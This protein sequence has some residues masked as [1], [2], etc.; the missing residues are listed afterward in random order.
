MFAGYTYMYV[1]TYVYAFSSR[2]SVQ[3]PRTD[4]PHEQYIPF[5]WRSHEG[6]WTSFSI[7]AAASSAL[8]SAKSTKMTKNHAASVFKV[9]DVSRSRK[10]GF[11]APRCREESRKNH[12]SKKHSWEIACGKTLARATIR[13][14]KRKDDAL[15]S[16]VI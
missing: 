12:S 5:S 14:I 1:Y 9:I 10:L 13:A 15:Q 6:L 4:C 8:S 3:V 2:V 16:F 7:G 11:S